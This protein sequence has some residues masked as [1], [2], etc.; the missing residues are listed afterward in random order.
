[1]LH[2]GDRGNRNGPEFLENEPSLWCDFW[3]AA[4]A[5]LQNNEK[6]SVRSEWPW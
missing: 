5:A 2:S 1:M 4:R 3:E 6:S